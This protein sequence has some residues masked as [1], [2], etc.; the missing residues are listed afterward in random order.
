MI[1][2][3][4]CG[5]DKPPHGMVLSERAR[6]SSRG[7]PLC[8]RFVLCDTVGAMPD[9]E[10]ITYRRVLCIGIYLGCTRNGA[11]VKVWFGFCMGKE[12]TTHRPRQSV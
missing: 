5:Q 6:V 3:V 2:V 8:S 12:G 10:H 9:D 11:F 4:V 1:G 7:S